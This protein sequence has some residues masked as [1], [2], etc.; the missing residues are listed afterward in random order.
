MTK[1]QNVYILVNESSLYEHWNQFCCRKVSFLTDHRCEF[2]CGAHL[3]VFVVWFI[4][5]KLKSSFWKLYCMHHDLVNR[6]ENLCHKLRIIIRPFL[7]HELSPGFNKSK[8]LGVTSRAG[9]ANPSEAPAM[10]TGFYSG[11]C[12][13]IFCFQCTACWLIVSVYIHMSFDIPF[14]RLFGVR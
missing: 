13:L 1:G 5:V 8:T 14:V 6:Y 2:L 9:T 12:W 11:S 3:A 7:I 10:T 4:V